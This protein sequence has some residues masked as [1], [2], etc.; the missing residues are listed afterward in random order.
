[1]CVC[2]LCRLSP[3]SCQLAVRMD[4]VLRFDF[5]IFHVQVILVQWGN[6][7]WAQQTYG[8]TAQHLWI[9]TNAIGFQVTLIWDP[10]FNMTAPD[11]LLHIV[12]WRGPFRNCLEKDRRW[13]KYLA[14][15]WMNHLSVNIYHGLTSTNQIDKPYDQQSKLVNQTFNKVSWE[16]SKKELFFHQEKPPGLF[17]DL[18]Q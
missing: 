17:F 3:A 10:R 2:V 7:S 18:F 4:S 13:K 8:L 9:F 1:M 12:I 5:N 11:G 6:C 16:K 15:D 14:C